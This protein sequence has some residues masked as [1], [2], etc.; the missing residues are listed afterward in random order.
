MG[1]IGDVISPPGAADPSAPISN[2]TSGRDA[3]LQP[4][5]IDLTT[6]PMVC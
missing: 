6:S 3:V 1:L 5:L 4:E 2:A